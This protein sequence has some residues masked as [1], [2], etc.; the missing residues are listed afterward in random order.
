MAKT[1]QNVLKLDKIG[2]IC[3]LFQQDLKNM[4]L[5]GLPILGN[6]VDSH[7]HKQTNHSQPE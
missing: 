3:A 1:G 2:V 5:F 4:A 7:P 6:E